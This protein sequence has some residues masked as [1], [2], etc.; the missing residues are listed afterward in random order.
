[1]SLLL[2][3][4]HGVLNNCYTQDWINS[5]VELFQSRAVATNERGFNEWNT[6]VG[7]HDHDFFSKLLEQ[8]GFTQEFGKPIIMSLKLRRKDMGPHSD[9]PLTEQFGT[10]YKSYLIP[11][12]NFESSSTVI[13]NQTS[14]DIMGKHALETIVK[15]LPVLP[16]NENACALSTLDHVSND[17][18]SRLSVKKVL[19]WSRDAIVYWNSNLLHC[20]CVYNEKFG[21][22]RDAV[23]IWTVK[24]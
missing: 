2:T 1:M 9:Y 21:T 16:D 11:L 19:P 7:S 6:L 10:P 20:S 12:N 15:R 4:D 23:I 8:V 14:S 17:V 18:K 5:F 3:T 24:D 22:S 13:F